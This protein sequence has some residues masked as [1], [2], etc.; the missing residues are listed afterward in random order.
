MG[1]L[2]LM[3]ISF[4]AM[5]IVSVSAAILPFNG[6]TT[7]DVA[8]SYTILAYPSDY[9]FYVVALIYLSILYWIYKQWQM[10]AKKQ[11]AITHVQSFLF[12]ISMVL[13]IVWIYYWQNSQFIIACMILV[14]STLALAGMYLLLPEKNTMTT[15]LPISLYLAWLVLLVMFNLAILLVAA[16]WDGFGLSQPLWAVILLTVFV[17]IA[18][19]IRFHHYDPY[20]PI[21]FIW[22][23]L[24]IAVQNNFEELLVTTAAL[25][26]SGVLLAGILFMRKKPRTI[27]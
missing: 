1:R 5:M 8:N 27:Y 25:F 3:T 20:F 16:R 2:L 9:V 26:L 13:S 10:F 15:R 6:Q 12:T 23:Y 18:L 21:L 17:A 22:F 14:F 24:G 11:F 7:V 19:H 4:L